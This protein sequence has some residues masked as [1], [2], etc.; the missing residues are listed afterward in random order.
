MVARRVR[1]ALQQLRGGPPI[2]TA[3]QHEGAVM[4]RAALIATLTLATIAGL[5]ALALHP[6]LYPN[7]AT[8]TGDP[9]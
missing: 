6:A 5:C 9:T 1:E 3:G 8:D 7:D 2:F 4:T